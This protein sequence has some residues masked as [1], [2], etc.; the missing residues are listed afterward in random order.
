MSRPV[1]LPGPVL[2]VRREDGLRV[3]LA[4]LLAFLV[5]FHWVALGVR[6]SLG[7]QSLAAAACEGDALQR[8]WVMAALVGGLA[9]SSRWGPWGEARHAREAQGEA[10][11]G[12][13]AAAGG[14]AE[15]PEV[16][17]GGA[18]LGAY[19]LVRKLGEGGMGVVYEARHALLPRKV[20]LKV[21]KPV[22][23]NA[24]G[25]RRFAREAQLTSELSHPNTVALYDYAQA[26][27]GSCYYAMEFIEGMDLEALV[28]AEGPLPAGRVL[29]IL[30][31]V[32]AS[33]SEAHRKG[34]M[35][36]DIK[37]SNVMVGCR[38]GAP[39][40][41]KV[42][43]FGLSRRFDEGGVRGERTSLI[44][45]TPQLMAPEALYDS[46][47]LG[48]GADV[49]GVGALG[50][51][52]LTGTFP[53]DGESWTAIANAHLLSP[54]LPPSL[55]TRND[56]PRDFE[57]VL[58]R[59]LAK[60]PYERPADGQALLEALEGCGESEG[61][62]RDEAARWWE[63]L[64]DSAVETL[65][66]PEGAAEAMTTRPSAGVTSVEPPTVVAARGPADAPMSGAAISVGALSVGKGVV[67]VEGPTMPAASAEEEAI[68]TAA[69][70][71]T[72]R[73]EAQQAAG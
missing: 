16:L 17:E 66:V 12:A 3:Y 33:L 41:V 43:D 48:P 60:L 34:V 20:A 44:A 8:L 23:A 42:L 70:R 28:R 6:V 37:P 27:D 14:A 7:G 50:Y 67:A 18:Q 53:F 72:R 15:V 59:C 71:L 10:R 29:H 24:A 35:H 57:D 49:Y 40:F 45:G 51:F 55:R 65:R 63:E 47:A 68:V 39:D 30:R 22:H 31:Q 2:R 9:L 1:R 58:M 52:L 38:D 69:F 32:A 21:I 64:G 56:V 54:P 73:K 26:A 25:V 13:E 5:G 36:R 19:T 11:Q 61:W 4:A 46:G 62:S